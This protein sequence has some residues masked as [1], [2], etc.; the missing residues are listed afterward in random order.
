MSDIKHNSFFH[1]PTKSKNDK[2][3]TGMFH[4]FDDVLCHAIILVAMT[5]VPSKRQ[6]NNED[7][8][9]Q[10]KARRKKEELTKEKTWKRQQRSILKHRI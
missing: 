10:A 2:K 8:E 9:L 4:S 3:A 6:R 7:L 1:R 5:D